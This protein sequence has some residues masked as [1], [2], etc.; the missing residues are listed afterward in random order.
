M[1]KVR[2]LVISL[3]ILVLIG[4][5][6]VSLGPLSGPDIASEDETTVARQSTAPITDVST[7]AP[8]S[9]GEVPP[10]VVERTTYATSSTSG[11]VEEPESP[12]A[13]H[14]LPVVPEVSQRSE[15]SARNLEGADFRD[16]NL[17]GARFA[18]ANMRRSSWARAFV[19]RTYG[20]P[21]LKALP[22][23]RG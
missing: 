23:S 12:Q 17:N 4:L 3:A 2:A 1:L 14:T 8:S 7:N 5:G 22:A 15:V 6:F 13:A 18:N 21:I 20:V 11:S 16:S 19:V 9:F 10:V